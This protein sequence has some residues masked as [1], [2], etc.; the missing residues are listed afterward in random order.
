MTRLFTVGFA[1]MLYACRAAGGAEYFTIEVIDSQTRRGVPL[2]EVETVN[3]LKF[4]TDSNGIVA[5]HE[6]GMMDQKV[7][8]TF[9]SH[10]YELPKDGFGF[11]GKAIDLK[12]STSIVIV[13]H[14]K[15]LFLLETVEIHFWF[16]SVMCECIHMVLIHTMQ[17]LL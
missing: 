17:I 14:L 16:K 1:L 3:S 4:I 2:V 8:F 12:L 10:G 11:A 5:F 9:K 6:P 15:G 13:F 7:F